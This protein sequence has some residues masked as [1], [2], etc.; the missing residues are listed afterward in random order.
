MK[1]SEKVVLVLS[2]AV[3]SALAGCGGESDERVKLSPDNVYTNNH[4]VHGAG[5]YHAPFHAWYPYPFNAFTPNRGYYYGGTWNAS[6]DERA[7]MASK[8][9]PTA[10]SQ[11]VTAH[12]TQAAATRRGGFGSSSRSGIS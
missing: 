10:V 1:R 8:P 9:S 11:A 2:G 7:I 3:A 5:Y 12:K 6:P 4:Y